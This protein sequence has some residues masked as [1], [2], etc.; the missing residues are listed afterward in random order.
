MTERRSSRIRVDLDARMIE[1]LDKLARTW[2]LSR[3]EAAG[4]LILE[5]RRKPQAP[6]KVSRKP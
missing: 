4:R 2:G 6:K 1:S 5:V 3:S